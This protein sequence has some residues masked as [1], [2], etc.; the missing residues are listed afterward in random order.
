MH[1]ASAIPAFIGGIGLF[2]LGMRLMTDGLTASAGGAL[3]GILSTATRNPLRAV[4]SGLL[5]TTTVQSSSAVIFAT[6]GF[7]NAGLLSLHQAIGVIYGANLGTTLTS[8]LV[9]VTGFDLDIGAWALPAIGIGAVLWAVARGSRNGAL[10]QALAGFGLFF[11]GISVLHDAFSH[12]GNDFSLDAIGGDS[13]LGI[14]AFVAIGIVLTLLTQSSSATLAIT[15][16]AAGGGLVSLDHAAGMI[17]GA[18]VGTTSTAVLAA[19]GATAPAKRVAAAHVAFNV[20]TAAAALLLLP[21][22]LWLA[23]TIGGSMTGTVQVALVLAVFHTLTKLLGIGLMWPLTPRLVR[24]LERRFRGTGE[25]EGKPRFLDRNVQATPVLAVDALGLE[26][27]RM[28]TIANGLCISVLEGAD[29]SNRAAGSARLDSLQVAIGEFVAGIPRHDDDPYLA[30]TL[31]T[32]LRIAQYHVNQGELARELGGQRANAHVEVAGPAQHLAE[33]RSE[34]V[35]LLR[36]LQRSPDDGA[37]A[38]AGHVRF[39]ATYQAFKTSLLRAGTTGLVEPQRMA[40][41]LEYGSTL[42]RICDQA[43][44][45]ALHLADFSRR[46]TPHDDGGDMPTAPAAQTG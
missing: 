19:L 22:L 12:L 34:A 26:L 27:R 9:A 42:R 2:L 13:P 29:R 25:D 16:T 6:I 5:I 23:R 43:V 17:I 39:E 4:G 1:A 31:P 44:K 10:G 37:A 21:A 24:M 28:G 38:S 7:V 41:V 3:R 8:W 30:D 11:L 18:N 15:L 33:L 35:A 36:Q 45:A 40:A 46:T 32:A 14:L 20:V